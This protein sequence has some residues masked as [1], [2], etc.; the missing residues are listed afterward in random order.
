MDFSFT[1]EQVEI[2]N[3]T[4][5][6]L[7]GQV[8]PDRL[9]ELEATQ[10]WVDRET[11][12]ELAK[13]NLLGISLP[14]EYGGSG[15]GLIEQ[16]LVLKQVG[17]ALAHVPVLATTLM[18]ALPIARFGTAEQAQA[19]VPGA[20]DGSVILTSALVEPSD[21]PATEPDTVASKDGDAWVLDGA[22]SC[23]TAGLIAD[24]ILVPAR[25]DEGGI[26]VFLVD[27][28]AAGVVVERQETTNREPEAH[29]T[30][31]GVRVPAGDRLGGDSA[32]GVAITRWI[33]QHATLGWC[34]LQLGVTEKATEE[35]AA[36]T[37]TREQ[38]QR[39]L[40]H[41]QAVAQRAADMFIDVEGIRLTLWQAAWR[42]EVG[43][44]ADDEIAIAKFWAADGGHRVA[45]GGVHLH[46]GVG[47]DVDGTFHRYFIWAKKIEFVLGHS[48]HQLLDIGRRLAEA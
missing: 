12:A 5:R 9:K 40:A 42:L 19:W 36:Y 1:D 24:R 29:V 26:G 27:P 44:P 10:E 13:S 16:A 8:T 48:T 7:A 2:E 39:P 23:V 6:I 4:E 31:Q 43:R 21:A 30:L 18:G 28:A 37:S 41:F 47:V 33:E 3:L 22:K 35:T 32:D 25:L 11:Y 34:A 20:V 14:E 15:Y 38:F 46:G 17:R 45:H